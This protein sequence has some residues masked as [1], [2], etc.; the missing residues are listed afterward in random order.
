MSGNEARVL[1]VHQITNRELMPPKPPESLEKIWAENVFNLSK[2]PEGATCAVNLL[3][4]V[5]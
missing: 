1:A 3:L 5:Q 4:F 2:M